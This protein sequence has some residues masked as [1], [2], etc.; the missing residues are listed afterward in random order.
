VDGFEG[1]AT[2]LIKLGSPKFGGTDVVLITT[3]VL[4]VVRVMVGIGGTSVVVSRTVNVVIMQFSTA[5]VT[6]EALCWWC[7]GGPDVHGCGGSR[8]VIER[9]VGKTVLFPDTVTISVKVV[10][11]TTKNEVAVEQYTMHAVPSWVEAV[12]M[13]LDCAAV[14]KTVVIWAKVSVKIVEAGGGSKGEVVSVVELV[15]VLMLTLVVDSAVKLVVGLVVTPV[16]E[17]AAGVSDVVTLGGSVGLLDP[18]SECR[19]VDEE[20]IPAMPGELWPPSGEGAN[21]DDHSGDAAAG[22]VLVKRG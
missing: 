5:Q 15:A 17:G 13:Q 10:T 8:V 9:P 14:G 21:D 11:L 3:A 7:L 20:P 4:L 22:V 19:R 1:G 18:E 6:I 16:L 2:L 12:V